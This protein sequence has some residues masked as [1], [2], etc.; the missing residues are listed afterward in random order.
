MLQ[1]KKKESGL[2]MSTH[3]FHSSREKKTKWAHMEPIHSYLGIYRHILRS[4]LRKNKNKK[5]V[6]QTYNF[7]AT[8]H[9]K[10]KLT[11]KEPIA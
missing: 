11:L 3:N 8:S 7:L 10:L 2:T 1:E 6:L 9:K 4:F 5:M